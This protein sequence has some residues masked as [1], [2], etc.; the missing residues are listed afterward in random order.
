[1]RR[2]ELAVIR[3]AIISAGLLLWALIMLAGAHHA[4]RALEVIQ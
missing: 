3:A 4:Y 2:Y 1:M